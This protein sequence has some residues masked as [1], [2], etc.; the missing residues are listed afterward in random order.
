MLAG[1]LRRYHQLTITRSG[2]FWRW[3]TETPFDIPMCRRHRTGTTIRGGY[4]PVPECQILRCQHGP[5]GF[6]GRR[7]LLSSGHSILG[8]VQDC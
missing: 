7:V 2:N 4:R 1:R 6:A 3:L 8:W 5:S